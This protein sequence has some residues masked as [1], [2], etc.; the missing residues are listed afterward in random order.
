MKQRAWRI[1][2]GAAALVVVL[3]AVLVVTH[4]GAVRDH[5]KAWHFQLTRQTKALHPF[6]DEAVPYATEEYQ[7]LLIMANS[8]RS[9]VI[10]DPK[11]RFELRPLAREAGTIRMLLESNG[12]RFF[13]QELPR[14]AYVLVPTK[15]ATRYIRWWETY[16]AGTHTGSGL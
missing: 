9:P 4:W 3:L 14:K 8:L 1:T 15:G 12:W 13:E 10:F 6:G 5:V 2:I 11:E 16:H 7:L